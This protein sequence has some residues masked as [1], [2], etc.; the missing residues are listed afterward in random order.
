MKNILLLPL[1]A[2][3][4]LCLGGCASTEVVR[5]WKAPTGADV[6]VPRVAVV[7]VEDR[8]M[9]RQGIENRLVSELGKQGQDAIPTHDLLSLEEIKAN[10]EVAAAR[11][12]QEGAQAVLIIRVL[13]Q[14]TSAQTVVSGSMMSDGIGWYDYFTVA[15]FEMGTVRGIT[16]QKFYFETSLHDLKT[17]QRLWWAQS[18]TTLKEDTDKLVAA[19]V[20]AKKLAKALRKDGVIR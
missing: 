1:F 9:I 15:F 10:K 7:A 19:D 3:A 2:A 14:T 4:A 12:Q 16:K 6:K 5:T 13:D 11:V 8:L 18:V 17:G 20:L